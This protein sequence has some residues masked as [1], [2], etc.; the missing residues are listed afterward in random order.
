MSVA[1]LGCNN[2]G[3]WVDLEGTRAVVDASLDAGVTLFDTAAIYGRQGGTSPPLVIELTSR[4]EDVL[5][6]LY[7]AG[8]ARFMYD[9]EQRVFRIPAETD[10]HNRVLVARAFEDDLRRLRFAFR[11]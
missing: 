9:H 5:S 11:A 7:G 2:F 1:G 10:R 4:E 3:M 8:F 6:L